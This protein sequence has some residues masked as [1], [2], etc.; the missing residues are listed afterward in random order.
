MFASSYDVT[1]IAM[2]TLM[3]YKI[4]GH[5]RDKIYVNGSILLHFAASLHD[6]NT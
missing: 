1:F 5:I 4:Q 3:T 6:E 2:E